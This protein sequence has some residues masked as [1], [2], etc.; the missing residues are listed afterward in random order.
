LQELE[1]LYAKGEIEFFYGDESH[2]CT[3][4]YVPYGWQFPAE[5]IYIPSERAKRL[6]ILGMISRDKHFED[7]CTSESIDAEKVVCFLEQFSFRVDKKTF[8]V[9]DNASIHRNAK[10]RQM[11]S[12][13]NE[14]FFSSTCL[15]I[16]LI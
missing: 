5:K 1:T 11:P 8:V 15:P 9:L 12:G 6:N 13:K 7:F 10:I 4:G 14:D 2:V 16:P 3:E